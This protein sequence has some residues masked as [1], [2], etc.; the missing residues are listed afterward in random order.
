VRTLH[1]IFNQNNVSIGLVE[2]S[3]VKI[4]PKQSKGVTTSSK[5]SRSPVT[6]NRAI[7]V[8]DHDVEIVE[9]VVNALAKILKGKEIK[10]L[11]HK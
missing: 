6:A 10:M 2:K 11:L 3:L 4:D 5:M 9:V 8:D 7:E 1:R